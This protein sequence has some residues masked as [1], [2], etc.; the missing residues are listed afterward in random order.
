MLQTVEDKLSL[1]FSKA[2]GW[3]AVFVF[4]PDCFFQPEQEHSLTVRT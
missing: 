2:I 4:N 3:A 1:F